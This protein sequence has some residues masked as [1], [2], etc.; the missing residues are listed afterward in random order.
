MNRVDDRV[1]SR[2]SR[3][4]GACARLGPLAALS[5][6]ALASIGCGTKTL[7]PGELKHPSVGRPIGDADRAAVIEVLPTG[8]GV[9]IRG[10]V[11][12][13]RE[14]VTV[15]EHDTLVYQRPYNAASDI[16]VE[17][18]LAIATVGIVPLVMA[19]AVDPVEAGRVVQHLRLDPA[20]DRFLTLNG[21]PF[22][23][24]NLYVHVIVGPAR[25]HGG[26]FAAWFLIGMQAEGEAATMA[27]SPRGLAGLRRVM[28]ERK[29][30]ATNAINLFE[31]A[32][33]DPSWFH[34]DVLGSFKRGEGSYLIPRSVPALQYSSHLVDAPEASMT[35]TSRDGERALSR[36]ESGLFVVPLD[37]VPK[38]GEVTFS[39]NP[40]VRGAARVERNVDAESLRRLSKGRRA[41]E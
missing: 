30:E 38:A 4:Y 9:A 25:S 26:T 23:E 34:P 1:P 14:V 41:H 37:A 6:F 32:D 24:K 40:R 12:E 19:I 2:L 28:R 27:L 13:S 5:L 29:I 17:P 11:L 36:G 8:N 39:F 7:I 10:A 20:H 31:V 3:A 16:F 21:D 18:L 35:M 15:A 22:D 33:F